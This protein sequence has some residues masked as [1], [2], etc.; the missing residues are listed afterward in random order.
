M[1]INSSDKE[2]LHISKTELHTMMESEVSFGFWPRN[3]CFFS[4]GAIRHDE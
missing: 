3:V 1:V 2:R 4:G